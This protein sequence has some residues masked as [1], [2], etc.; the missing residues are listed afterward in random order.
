MINAVQLTE[1]EL[2]L[3]EVLDRDI[4]ILDQHKDSLQYKIKTNKS[5]FARSL[6][7]GIVLGGINAVSANIAQS[8]LKD[9]SSLWNGDGSLSLKVLD[10]AVGIGSW[11]GAINEFQKDQYNREKAKQL[12]KDYP[13]LGSKAVILAG[14]SVVAMVSGLW[15]IK[16]VYNMF[17]FN[18]FSVSFYIAKCKRRINRD[19]VIIAQLRQLKYDATVLK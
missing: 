15:C 10:S 11:F 7:G 8:E 2:S 12:F 13:E 19:E 4:Q 3:S 5:G 17:K 9:I 1:S 18:P 6:T 14:A 16:K